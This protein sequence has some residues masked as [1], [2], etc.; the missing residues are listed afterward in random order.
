MDNNFYIS[1]NCYKAYLDFE[2]EILLETNE[3]VINATQANIKIDISKIKKAYLYQDLKFHQDSLKNFFHFNDF[4]F[5]KNY[6]SWRYRVYYFR[7]ISPEY[8]LFEHKIW[9]QMT[10]KFIQSQYVGAISLIYDW[11]C[12]NHELLKDMAISHKPNELNLL[13]NEIFDASINAQYEKVLNHAL[14]YSRDLFSFCKFFSTTITNVMQYVGYQW[15]VNKLTVAKEHLATSNIDKLAM[16]LLNNYQP[17][18]KKNQTI[19]IAG[20]PNEY[21]SLGLKV[22][23]LIIEKLGYTTINLGAN[24]PKS[25]IIA[26]CLEFDPKLILLSSSLFTN[27]HFIEE[28]VDKLKSIDGITGKI[29]ISGN[30]FLSLQNPLEAINCDYHIKDYLELFTLLD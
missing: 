21:H 5:L 6:L 13:E 12:S 10:Q 15:E 3:A 2:Y 20:A 1:K 30:S 16:E 18:M 17:K 23:V 7:G 8:L 27:I 29:G 9:Q 28:I 11:I 4:E 26:S 14:L 22:A 19:L 25:Q 24:A